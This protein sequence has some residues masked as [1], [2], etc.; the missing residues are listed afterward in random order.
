LRL[1]QENFDRFNL[2][3]NFK[4]KEVMEN[5]RKKLFGLA[6]AS[7]VLM[8]TFAGQAFGQ[9]T[10]ASVPVLSQAVR[11]E[12]GSDLTAES[13]LTCVTA[14]ATPISAAGPPDTRPAITLFVGAP[15]TSKLLQTGAPPLIQW[16]EAIAIV[17]TAAPSQ[18]ASL[19]APIFSVT[20][21]VIT[22]AGVSYTGILTPATTLVNT[23][24]AIV[25]ANVRVN[26]TGGATSIAEQAFITG[27]A[28][29]NPGATVSVTVGTVASGLA[30]AKLSTDQAN[31]KVIAAAGL[32]T[33]V[34]TALAAQSG[35]GTV[36]L[37]AAGGVSQT[38]LFYIHTGETFQTSFKTLF[39]SPLG[40]GTAAGNAA[41]GSEFLN[42]SETGLVPNGVPA[43]YAF[44]F[45]FGGNNA[46]SGTRLQVV[47]NN[48][49]AGMALYAPLLV[50]NDNAAPTGQLSLTSSLTGPF[51]APTPVQATGAFGTFVVGL[52]AFGTAQ[53]NI[54]HGQISQL[55][56]SGTTAT[57]V[58]EVTTQSPIAIEAYSIPI[59]AVA[60]AGSL[61]PTTAPLTVTV[62]FAPVP[63]ALTAPLTNIPSFVNLSTAVNVSNEV[64]C[65]T[66]LLFPYVTQ[67]SGFDVGIA[68]EDTSVDNLA[69]GGK[70]SATN[71]GGTC[72]LNYYGVGGSITPSATGTLFVNSGS[73]TAFTFTPYS[74]T[75]AATATAGPGASNLLSVLNPGFTGY[76]IAQCGF[77]FAHGYAYVFTNY[78][79]A[80]AT[81]TSYLPLVLQ[82]GAAARGGAEF[83]NGAESAA[84]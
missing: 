26:A 18:A 8:C 54:N 62:S 35:S 76:I 72:G 68:I 82:T 64:S 14:A 44:P 48:I 73:T 77:Q 2:E 11:L 57:A 71:Q 16:T 58:Y 79:T 45:P 41:T 5:L 10:C 53:A 15:V 46:S 60:A 59:F 7:L 43:A 4:E 21:G 31:T 42:N 61:V 75:V 32:N 38:P 23:T 27:S 81:V 6:G 69:T 80:N 51:G 3:I 49:P 34:C 67:G 36:L 66:T 20:Q 56:V 78:G 52:T 47:I 29:M 33:T 74:S 9:A 37:P 1:R 55:T 84:H 50:N 25:F 40:V 63:T 65:S 22:P 30:P 19:A 13:Q 12:S 24:Y 83:V 28:V 17:Y 70:S 39:A